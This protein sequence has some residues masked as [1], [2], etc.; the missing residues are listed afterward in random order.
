MCKVRIKKTKTFCNSNS[1]EAS[2]KR[3]RERERE[4]ERQ[5]ERQTYRYREAFSAEYGR[6]GEHY[7]SEPK[8]GVKNQPEKNTKICFIHFLE[9]H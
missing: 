5:R 4:R 9:L 2:L 1:D 7:L 8:T 3:E 6:I